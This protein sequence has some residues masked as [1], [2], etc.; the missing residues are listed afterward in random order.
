[1]RPRNAASSSALLAPSGAFCSGPKGVTPSAPRNSGAM[2]ARASQEA[3]RKLRVEVALLTGGAGEIPCVHVDAR[4][5]LV[6]T[7]RVTALFSI[8]EKASLMSSS[9]ILREIIEARSS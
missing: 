4:Q 7:E 5:K 2:L 1:M 3:S 9:L 6:I 8:A